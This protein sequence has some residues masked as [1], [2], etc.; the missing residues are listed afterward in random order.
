[1]PAHPSQQC[2]LFFPFAVHP[3][4][5]RSFNSHPLFVSPLAILPT[6]VF[7]VGILPDNTEVV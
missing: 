7:L 3:D 2:Q 1:M 6:A 5:L 4:S